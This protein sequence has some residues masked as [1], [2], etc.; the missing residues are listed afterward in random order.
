MMVLPPQL[1][2]ECHR[3]KRGW[4]K[5]VCGGPPPLTFHTALK[6]RPGFDSC[7]Q[8]HSVVAAMVV[9]QGAEMKGPCWLA[10]AGLGREVWDTQARAHNTWNPCLIFFVPFLF[11][12]SCVVEPCSQKNSIVLLLT[13]QLWSHVENCNACH[14]LCFSV[15][16][17]PP[18][19]QTARWNFTPLK[20]SL[21]CARICPCFC[22]S[23]YGVQFLQQSWNT[24]DLSDK[25]M[26]IYRKARVSSREEIHHHCQT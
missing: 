13:Q 22:G 17:S 5:K 7:R 3:V 10:E 16:W 18:D 20:E 11:L 19:F 6:S 26:N 25:Q 14:G 15:L 12:K 4:F 2:E 8:C 23:S 21:A 9:C 24:L 1:S